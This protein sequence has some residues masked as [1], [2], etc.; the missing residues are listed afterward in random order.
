LCDQ[1]FAHCLTA[2]NLFTTQRAIVVARSC[3]VASATLTIATTW[4]LPVTAATLLPVTAA[5][6]LP[7]TAAAPFAVAAWCS[8]LIAGTASWSLRHRACLTS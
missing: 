6:L 1:Q 3:V 7:I 4:L 5:T 2:F 8:A